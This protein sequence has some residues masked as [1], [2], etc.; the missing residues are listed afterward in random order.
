MKVI[1]PRATDDQ[2]EHAFSGANFG[3]V[4]HRHMLALSVLKKALKYHCGSTITKIRMDMG[5]TTPT[6]RV[7]EKG[8]LFCYEQMDVHQ[9]G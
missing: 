1:E 4:D 6:G 8:R 2:I 9:V 7:T 3:P 5:L